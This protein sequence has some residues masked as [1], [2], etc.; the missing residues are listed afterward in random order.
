M[1]YS[2]KFIRSAEDDLFEIYKYIYVNDIPSAAD[3]I[4]KGI[5]DKCKT[6]ESF[7]M[8]GHIP[9][10]LAAVN[11][12]DYLEVHFK[13]FRIVYQVGKGEVFIHSILDGRREIKTIL[14]ERVSRQ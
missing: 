13:P 5:M 9:P 7:P 4:Y 10:E 11:M 14:E 3:K 2:V 6:L 1:K 12:K 8:R